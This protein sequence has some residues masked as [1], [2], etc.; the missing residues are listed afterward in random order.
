MSLQT[1]KTMVP[2]AMLYFVRDLDAEDPEVFT[3]AAVFFAATMSVV[4]GS[5]LY[6][7]RLTSQSGDKS[8]IKVT[9]KD[10]QQPNPLGD[11]LAQK[12]DPS[13]AQ[14][15]EKEMTVSRSSGYDFCTDFI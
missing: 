3:K 2:L 14:Q 5:W 6:L 11:A 12:L 8:V 10:L 13:R 1:V 4:L 7:L 15:E 9:E